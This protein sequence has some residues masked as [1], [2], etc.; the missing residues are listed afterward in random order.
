MQFLRLFLLPF[1]WLYG[2]VMAIRNSLYDRQILKSESFPIPTI[3]VGNLTA[4]G[5]GKTPHIEYLIRLLKDKYRVATL[6]R[7]YGRKSKGFFIVNSEDS[8]MF[9]DEP[10]QYH[11][12]FEGITVAVA[13]KR[14]EG[15]KNLITQNSPPQVVLL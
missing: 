8:S 14:S 5:T 1:G 2:I 7:G 11:S 10:V 3:A 12:K 9:G 4:G 13:E 15:I 6:S